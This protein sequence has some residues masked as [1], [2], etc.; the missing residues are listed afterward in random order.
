MRAIVVALLLLCS[1]GRVAPAAAQALD[2]R[3]MDPAIVGPG[4]QGGDACQKV[5]DVYRYLNPQL[6]L[7]ITGGN[8]TLG[9][10]GV[11]GGPGNFL[12]G[13][14]VNI[15]RA[16]IPQL[17]EIGVT[18]GP[19][20]ADE[21]RTEGR[22]VPLPT[23]DGSFGIFRGVPVGA[24]HIGGIDLLVSASF[25]LELERQ[26]VAI[27][28]PGSSVRFGWGA[29]VGLIEETIL[30]PAISVTYIRRDIPRMTLRA[31]VADDT[32]TMQQ[33]D[34]RTSAWRVVAGKHLGRFS[35]GGGVGQDRYDARSELTYVVR[36]GGEV[37]R[38]AV[39]FVLT[40]APT[41]LNMFLDASVFFGRVQ[42]LGEIGRVSGGDIP[43]YNRFTPRADAP[44]MYG[45]V[46]LRFGI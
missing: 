33:L 11:L 44:R 12:I 20:Q 25:M 22:A 34:I 21:Y 1:V 46:G 27:E 30:L 16:S 36:E 40:D 39:P 31:R 32:V 17:T 2:P 24:S 37:Y 45:T 4:L 18:V 8:A 29:R 7:L 9:Q 6:G 14:R 38:P 23:L 19:P 41:R 3:C 5:V 28:V 13:G 26:D 15:L 35:V 43:T 42:L 10:Y